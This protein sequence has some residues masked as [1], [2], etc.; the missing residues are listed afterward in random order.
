MAD[1]PMTRPMTLSEIHEKALRLRGV[2]NA[3]AHLQGESACKQGRAALIYL[4]EELSEEL[5]SALDYASTHGEAA[6]LQQA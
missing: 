2:L 1:T 4:A 5:E 6:A 3:V